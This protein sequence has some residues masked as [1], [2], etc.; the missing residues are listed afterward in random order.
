MMMEI[1]RLKDIR[2]QAQREE[3]RKVAAFA[4]AQKIVE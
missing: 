3:R 2:E 1:E 4:G